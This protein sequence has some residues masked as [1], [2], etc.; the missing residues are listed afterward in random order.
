MYHQI[1]ILTAMS[2]VQGGSGIHALNPSVYNYLCRT[3]VSDIIV[4]IDEVPDLEVRA[5]LAKV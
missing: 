3:P 1:G 4:G 5:M 2:V